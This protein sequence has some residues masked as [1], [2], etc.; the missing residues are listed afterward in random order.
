MQATVQMTDK[1]CAGATAHSAA[2]HGGGGQRGGAKAGVP[3]QRAQLCEGPGLLLP[4]LPAHPGHGPGD[5]A[6]C[7][8]AVPAPAHGP[9]SARRRPRRCGEPFPPSFLPCRLLRGFIPLLLPPVSDHQGV[10]IVRNHCQQHI[11]I[12]AYRAA[13]SFQ[14]SRRSCY[15]HHKSAYDQTVTI[16]LAPCQER[17]PA[18]HCQREPAALP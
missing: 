10:P 1:A 8:L 12:E 7:P 15:W 17:M 6:G 3:D 13:L 11:V 18:A 16:V 14:H 4:P 9:H 5:C 2:Q